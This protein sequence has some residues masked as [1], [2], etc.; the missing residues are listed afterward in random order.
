MIHQSFQVSRQ[1]NQQPTTESNKYSILAKR[2]HLF[3]ND[4]STLRRK[5]NQSR[6]RDWRRR[7]NRWVC[8]K[9]QVSQVQ[10]QQ[11]N[12]LLLWRSKRPRRREILKLALYRLS[13]RR[14]QRGV[15]MYCL[16]TQLNPTD[17]LLTYK[18]N[19]RKPLQTKSSS[20]SHLQDNL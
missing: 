20:K 15:R 3:N 5:I 16:Q 4:S 1:H 12:H 11:P 14:N 7:P 9:Q 6:S 13:Q 2:L 19:Q 17:N 18:S 10:F 8:R